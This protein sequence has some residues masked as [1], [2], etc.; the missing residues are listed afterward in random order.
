MSKK[1]K[2]KKGKEIKFK[3]GQLVYIVYNFVVTQVR[4]ECYTEKNDIT[5]CV[6]DLPIETEKGM[7]TIRITRQSDEVFYKEL[8]AIKNAYWQNY[9]VIQ[10]H[11]NL[12]TKLLH[13]L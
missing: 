1:N 12:I 9:N 5:Y 3:K 2:T 7:D 13:D 11:L 10:K 8:H 6:V 4:F